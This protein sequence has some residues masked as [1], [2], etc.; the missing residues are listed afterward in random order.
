MEI[1]EMIDWSAAEYRDMLADLKLGTYNPRQVEAALALARQFK[2][3]GPDRP[4]ASPGD[5][6][7]P[8]G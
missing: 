6:A 7:E 4:L 8:S 5:V 2:E 1:L 3:S